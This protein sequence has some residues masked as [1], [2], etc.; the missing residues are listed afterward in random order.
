MPEQWIR[1]A[2]GASLNLGTDVTLASI[3]IPLLERQVKLPANSV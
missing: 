1:L 2:T 3:P